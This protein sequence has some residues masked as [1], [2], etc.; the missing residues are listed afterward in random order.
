MMNGT[1]DHDRHPGHP[2]KHGWRR[3]AWLAFALALTFGI[4]NC[5]QT[6][7][8]TTE[9]GGPAPGSQS[10]GPEQD[11]FARLG[12]IDDSGK[13]EPGTIELSKRAGDRVQ[14]RNDSRDTMV[15]YLMDAPI[16]ELIPPG[17]FS[18]PHRVCVSCSTGFYPYVVRRMVSGLPERPSAGA[19]TEP[20]FGV[21]D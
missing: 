18:I 1:G 11:P 15:V 10:S 3:L 4:S 21:G 20:Q 8:P 16:G 19:P 5:G 9:T 7:P 13:V 17:K 6:T 12:A 2:T 14:W